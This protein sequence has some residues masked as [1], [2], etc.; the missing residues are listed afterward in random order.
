[1]VVDLSTQ[2]EPAATGDD[3]IEDFTMDHSAQPDSAGIGT[4]AV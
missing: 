3:A 2:P 4:E 1:M